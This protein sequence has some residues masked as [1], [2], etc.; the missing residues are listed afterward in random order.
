MSM[1]VSFVVFSQN[2]VEPGKT[3]WYQN[4][5]G[6]PQGAPSGTERTKVIVGL[7][8]E[9]A[10]AEDPEWYP[11][12]ALDSLRHPVLDT[13]LAW[14]REEGAKAWVRPNLSLYE[15]AEDI[16]SDELDM[17][18]SFLG[19]WYGNELPA[20][21]LD[22]R[23]VNPV[24]NV[25]GDSEF[26]LY[27]F[28][29]NVVYEWPWS[30]IFMDFSIDPGVMPLPE[31][32]MVVNKMSTKEIIYGDGK[33]RSVRSY[34]LNYLSNGWGEGMTL[35]EGIGPVETSNPFYGIESYVPNMKAWEGFCIA[36]LSLG[37]P[38]YSSLFNLPTI[39][40]L[41]YVED[42]EG[43]VIYYDD[44]YYETTGL[45]EVDSESRTVSRSSAYDLHGREVSAPVPGSIYIRDGK[46]FV[47]K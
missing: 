29:G 14:L 13:P 39:P 8:I 31:G 18:R 40:T 22:G 2:L 36:P 23:D 45:S 17:L 15:E 44:Y 6:I 16:E 5:L 46:K 42:G 27:D 4:Y 37:L 19:Y 3:W 34:T 24:W 47:S 26:L 35:I 28:D 1:L 21:R 9:D 10:L 41:I 20:V 12:V 25:K 7:R 30:G 11:C 32:G 43:Q 38:A 33:K